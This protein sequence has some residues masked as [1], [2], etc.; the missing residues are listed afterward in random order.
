MLK[1]EFNHSWKFAV[2]GQPF[3]PVSIP[4]DAMMLEPR[5]EEN[6]SGTGCAFFGGGCYEYEKEFVLPD[7]KSAVLHFEGAYPMAEIMLDG[8]KAASI[9]YGYGD[10]CV[11]CSRYADG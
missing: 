8:E 6:P 4:H 9:A 2:S 10:C 7:C 5:K 1:T 3:Q 11:D